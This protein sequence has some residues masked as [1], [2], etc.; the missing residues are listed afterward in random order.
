M[1]AAICV[2][3]I[4]SAKSAAAFVAPH[5]WGHSSPKPAVDSVNGVLSAHPSGKA[6]TSFLL[7]DFRVASGEVINPYNVL[8]VPRKATR[9]EIRA[10]YVT[11]SRRYHP[12]GFRQRTHILPGSCNNVD[13][14]R[15]QWERIKLA[16]E[17]LSNTK[18]R[19][20]YDR[21]E[22]L[23][24]PGAAVQRAALNAAVNSITG[25]GKSLFYVGSLA[26]TSVANLGKDGRDPDD[27]AS[28]N[29]QIV[30]AST[31]MP[32]EMLNCTSI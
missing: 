21:R 11:L 26:V 20:N 27:S 1:R 25:V 13:E 8:K 29:Q 5:P 6:E 24:D 9:D 3:V 31:G 15:D 2:L 7:K 32:S 22:V 18:T 14:V 17:I 19:K 4:L 16:Y 12:D 30:V 28:A 10:A 23:A